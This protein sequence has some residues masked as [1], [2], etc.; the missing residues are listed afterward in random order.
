MKKN[1]K[2]LMLRASSILLLLVMFLLPLFSDPEYS[3]ITNT[4]SDL[5]AQYAPNGRIMNFVFLL[6]AS[7][8]IY[9][10]WENYRG[11]IPHRIFL[12]LFAFS[13]ALAALFHHAPINPAIQYNIIENGWHNYFINTT[14][15]SFALLSIASG[16]I[17]EKE[18]ERTLALAA[19]MSVILLTVMMSEAERFA[20]I[21]QRLL[22]II[23]FGWLIYNF[24]TKDL[25]GINQ[26]Y[27]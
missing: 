22:F 27:L 19:G 10:G 12:L 25:P 23:A 5:G 16:F 8:T 18:K 7:C 11:F 6:L 26:E 9:S 24:R 1:N 14:G 17:P 15:L 21:W 2:I 4:L 13:L 20:G 3:I